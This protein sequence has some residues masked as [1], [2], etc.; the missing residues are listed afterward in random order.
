MTDQKRAPAQR[1]KSTLPSTESAL[2]FLT[3]HLGNADRLMEHLDELDECLALCH[4]A[5]LQSEINI[6]P[7]IERIRHVRRVLRAHEEHI[8]TGVLLLVV[9]QIFD[10]H[11]E[12][13]DEFHA[14]LDLQRLDKAVAGVLSGKT[15]LAAS[16]DMRQSVRAMARELRQKGVD[17]R[18]WAAKIKMKLDLNG[19]TLTE[20]TIRTYLKQI[21][22]E[23]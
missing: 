7:I 1:Q 2:A 18:N 4:A 16:N 13:L 6:Q 23:Q 8:E 12:I 11:R 19:T 3:E 20:K 10:I 9:I 21:D 17:R 14:K 22:E 15:R 5:D